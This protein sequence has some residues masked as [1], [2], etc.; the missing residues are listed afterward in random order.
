MEEF[1]LRKKI[2]SNFIPNVKVK[3][4]VSFGVNDARYIDNMNTPEISEEEFKRNF[5]LILNIFSNEKNFSIKEDLIILGPTKIDETLTLTWKGKNNRF[6]K[7][8]RIS[9]F[10]DILK[11]FSEEHTLLFLDLFDLL[12]EEDLIDGLHPNPEGHEK[13]KNEVKNFLIKK[14]IF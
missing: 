8:E 11:E 3:I 7:N 4:V 14:K 6:W 9:Q 2:F 1:K 10:R 12:Q 13:I 5:N